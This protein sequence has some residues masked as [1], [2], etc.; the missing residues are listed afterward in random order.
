MCRATT[1]SVPFSNPLGAL[2][3]APSPVGVLRNRSKRAGAA[4]NTI[5]RCNNSMAGAGKLRSGRPRAGPAS[6]LDS[7]PSTSHPVG[8]PAKVPGDDIPVAGRLEIEFLQRA[9]SGPAR[10]EGGL[11][12]QLLRGFQVAI[13]R[14]HHHHLLRLETKQARS[15]EGGFGIGR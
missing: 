10:D 14:G 13:M 1:A 5:L 11:Q 9:V 2:N 3:G 8:K 7:R 12:A 6:S 4:A 15:A